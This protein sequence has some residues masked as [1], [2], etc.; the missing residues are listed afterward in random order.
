[1]KTK[2]FF[3]LALVLGGVLTGCSTIRRPAGQVSA[4]LYV[5][6][7]VGLLGPTRCLSTRIRSGEPIEVIFVQDYD[8][9]ELKGRIDLQGTN[10]IADLAGG[11]G[12]EGW[13]YRGDITLE[14]PFFPRGGAS[15]GGAG[16]FGWFMVSTNSDFRVALHKV[17]AI[18]GLTNT[19]L[20]RP[21]AVPRPLTNTDTPDN[22]DPNIGLPQVHPLLDPNTG[23]P[24]SPK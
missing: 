22:V 10:F 21:A 15:S 17:N 5:H 19:P 24:L 20:R 6:F 11:T 9:T 14:K 2:L 1:M 4:P 8:Y 18:L 12:P 13:L 16:G 3:C 7:G 23:L